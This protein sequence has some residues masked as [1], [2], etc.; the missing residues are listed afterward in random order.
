MK[1]LSPFRRSKV[2]A[3][4][5]ILNIENF[6]RRNAFELSLTK[7]ENYMG[8]VEKN[9]QIST[10]QRDP[11]V[12]NFVS[13]TLLLSPQFANYISTLKANTLICFVEKKYE[14]LCNAKDSLIF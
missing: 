3:Q 1:K 7:D 6:N 13:F 14:N 10:Y 9:W 4:D 8:H 2:P 12:Q 11:V 5:R